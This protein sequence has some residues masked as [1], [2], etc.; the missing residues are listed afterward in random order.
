M[1]HKLPPAAGQADR[2]SRWE[3]RKEK[4]TEAEPEAIS[5]AVP[6]A[7]SFLNSGRSPEAS[8]V[9]HPERDSDVEQ[10]LLGGRQLFV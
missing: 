5:E 1:L 10:Q 6:A 9:R 2:R 4:T 7:A 3:P 8:L